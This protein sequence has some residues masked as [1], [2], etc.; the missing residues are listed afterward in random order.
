M[1]QDIAQI[2]NS[3]RVIVSADKTRNFYK[4]DALDYQKILRENVTKSYKLA[5]EQQLNNINQET[6]R[7]ATESNIA[8]RIEV[9]AKQE[10]YITLKDHKDNFVNNPTC[11]GSSTQLKVTLAA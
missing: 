5:K 3:D 7:M 10:A 11:I 4:M 9:M 1:K 2:K 6:K 8:D